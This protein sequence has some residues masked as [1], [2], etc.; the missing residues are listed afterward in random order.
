MGSDASHGVKI[1][2][3]EGLLVN[4]ARCCGPAAGDSIIGYIT[5]GRGVTVHRD[6]CSNVHNISD[7]ERLIEVTWGSVSDEQTYLVPIEV[8]AQDR[9]GLLRDIS[10]II[11][12]EKINITTV[13]VV[14][15]QQIATL[16]ITLELG[17]NHQLLRVLDK[18]EGI[19]SVHEAR[20]VNPG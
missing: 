5:R 6:D 13:E 12:D 10:T 4:M 1:M 14:T 3:A 17:D 19:P 7:T 15:R 11:A 18:I 20:R 2:G 16:Y 8:V 9:E